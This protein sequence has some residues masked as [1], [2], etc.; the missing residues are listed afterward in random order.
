MKKVLE[1]KVLE[2]NPMDYFDEKKQLFSNIPV[3]PPISEEEVQEAI[4]NSIENAAF[5]KEIE[6]IIAFSKASKN[7]VT[8]TSYIISLIEW[9]T[10]PQLIQ[11]LT[12]MREWAF[13]N[14]GGGVGCND[15]DDFDLLD[16]MKQLIILDTEADSIIGTIIGGYRY[17]F[18]D[19]ESYSTGPVGAH[20]Q[21][22]DKCKSE[23]WIEL[24]RSFINPWYQKRN[25]RLSFDLVL[26]GLGFIYANNQD[27]LGYFG[28]IT[29]YNVY[30]RQGADRFFL[31]VAKKYF[32]HSND[33]YVLSE[34]RI[35]EG[36]LTQD[37]IDFLDRDLFK[38]L[39]YLLRKE[40]KINL[41]PIMAVYNRLT[42]LS[43]MAY[44]GAFKHYSF[45]DS[46]EMGIAIAFEDIYPVIIEKFAKPYM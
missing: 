11:L 1:A 27:A 8:D 13:R 18:H 15:Y 46:I 21:F 39:F 22:S 42:P 35:L 9:Q 37:Q 20:Y 34:E 40:Y 4:E 19:A 33:I 44:F 25:Q 2:V 43:K 12:I 31:A 23:K 10:Y 5:E 24:G 16:K 38:G 29:L 45:G 17:M 14:E 7:Y 28:K 30:E 36:D 41:V 26:H 32:R 6:Q 3:F